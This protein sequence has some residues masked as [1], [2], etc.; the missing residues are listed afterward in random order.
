MGVQQADWYCVLILMCVCV[1]VQILMNIVTRG[2]PLEYEDFKSNMVKRAMKLLQMQF[3]SEVGLFRTCDDVRVVVHEKSL[4]VYKL[5][6]QT[7]PQL[8]YLIEDTQI[9]EAEAQRITWLVEQ[10]IEGVLIDGEPYYAWQDIMIKRN[11]LAVVLSVFDQELD[12]KDLEGDG[13]T[14]ALET[15]LCTCLRLVMYLTRGH[16]LAMELMIDEMLNLLK[17]ENTE[18]PRVTAALAVALAEVFASPKF[19]LKVRDIHLELIFARMFELY[20]EKHYCAELLDLLRSTAQTEQGGSASV[21]RNQGLIASGLMQHESNILKI[22]HNDNPRELKT[23]L[24]E[25]NTQEPSYQFHIS[26]VELLAMLG[27]GQNKF[28]EGICKKIFSV[29]MLL[30]VLTTESYRA[31]P[32]TFRAYATFFHDIYLSDSCLLPLLHSRPLAGDPRM[33]DVL[34]HCVKEIAR[35]RNQS[36]TKDSSSYMF[37]VLVPFLGAFFRKHYH[38]G[39]LHSVGRATTD[40]N[41]QGSDNRSFGGQSFGFAGEEVTTWTEGE[42]TDMCGTI[43]ASILQEVVSFIF[44]HSS[45]SWWTSQNHAKATRL[46]MVVLR[47]AHLSDDQVTSVFRLVCTQGPFSHRSEEDILKCSLD[48]LKDE[49]T[50]AGNAAPRRLSNLDMMN[51]GDVDGEREEKLTQSFQRFTLVMWQMYSNK[52]REYHECHLPNPQDPN[53]AR[54]PDCFYL[55]V[56]DNDETILPCGGEFQEAIRLF[57]TNE[58]YKTLLRFLGFLQDILDDVGATDDE[59]EEAR[60]FIVTTFKWLSA[61][62]HQSRCKEFEGENYEDVTS[63]SHT[64]L[65]KIMH[66]MQSKMA[67]AGATEHTITLI[68]DDEDDVMKAAFRYFMML[69]QDGNA[70]VQD[71]VMDAFEQSRSSKALLRLREELNRGT[72]ALRQLQQAQSLTVVDDVIVQPRGVIDGSWQGT[73]NQKKFDFINLG[74]SGH[75]C[76]FGCI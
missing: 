58:G 50:R 62:M 19:Q 41:D 33:W 26:L 72:S 53:E 31:V 18:S 34:A 10:L 6:D 21:T 30:L 15:A 74:M 45:S 65:I 48:D 42:A 43:A 56:D 51:T 59:R 70:E 69:L 20:D 29:E 7:L 57:N 25:P 24:H 68:A 16:D 5:V 37:K 73:M 40:A 13:N 3:S 55:E 27:E 49:L 35:L 12:D 28:I 46:L 64:N 54:N 38:P 4:N 63:E 1:S 76:T 17:N 32:K 61:I 71:L 11:V 67:L 36:L 14:T 44:S 2:R 66:K 75:Y 47:G 39:N 23:L 52:N 9:D 60:D 8:R 22:L